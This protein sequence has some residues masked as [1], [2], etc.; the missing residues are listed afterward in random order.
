MTGLPRARLLAMFAALIVSSCSPGA[1]LPTLKNTARSAYLLGPG[2][3]VRIIVY[4]DKPLS[5]DFRVND[6]G[7][8][9]LPLVGTIK[10]AGLNAQQLK[11]RITDS[12]KQQNLIKDPSVSAEV[13]NYR[14]IFILGE[15]TKP[16]QYPYQPGMTVLTAVAVAGGYTYR[17]VERYAAITRTQDDEAVEGRVTPQTYVSPGDVISIFERRF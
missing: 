2:D 16:G 9:D 7:E 1:D 3:Q 17:A 10:A 15:V 5:D 14:P 12:L 4:G 6:A 11:N 13:V 8:L